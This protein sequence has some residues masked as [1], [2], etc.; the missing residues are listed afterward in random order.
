[1]SPLLMNYYMFLKRPKTPFPTD[2]FTIS[3]PLKSAKR[4]FRTTQ[5]FQSPDFA[6]QNCEIFGQVVE[7][8]GSFLTQKFGRIGNTLHVPFRHN[9]CV[10]RRTL[11]SSETSIV[12]FRGIQFVEGPIG[13]VSGSFKDYKNSEHGK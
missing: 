11:C 6:R 3:E 2:L 8:A 4:R 13:L 9:K 12:V 5:S 10:D 7:P 1:M